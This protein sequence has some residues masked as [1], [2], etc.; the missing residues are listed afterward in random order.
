MRDLDREAVREL[1]K[2]EAV[3]IC[4]TLRGLLGRTARITLDDIEEVRIE[5]LAEYL[6]GFGVV[7]EGSQTSKD[8]EANMM[9]IFQRADIQSLTNYIM[10]LPANR[11]NPLDE[12]ALSALKEVAAQCIHA[13][14]EEMSDFLGRKMED[15]VT[16]AGAYD[17]VGSL[18]DRARRWKQG[19]TVYLVAY[20]LTIDSVCTT[21]AFTIMSKNM[22]T[23]LG[24][25]SSPQ[26]E[27]ADFT[28]QDQNN[29]M[30]SVQEV[31]FPEFQYTPTDDSV[32]HIEEDRKRLRDVTLDISVRIGSTVCSVKQILA[33]KP[34]QVLTL[35][36]QA[37]S[38]AD[39]LVNG[40]MI[41]KGD[42]VVTDDR[43]AARISEILDK[44]D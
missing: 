36:K 37:G 11:D 7:V 1:L 44:R 16:Q 12:I 14:G 33:M 43:F 23:V 27:A 18:L 6:P 10:G 24:I 15:T 17:G 2:M 26:P 35:D 4:N 9:Y 34:G 30:I 32:T 40:V 29:R 41:G 31:F 42:I 19:D 28:V 21:D 13:A 38:P 22:E 39:I 5:E 3:P 25:L 8:T 20:Q